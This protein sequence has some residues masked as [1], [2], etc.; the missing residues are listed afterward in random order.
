MNLA[1]FGL[2]NLLKPWSSSS[3]FLA[4]PQGPR[5]VRLRCFEPRHCQFLIPVWE[6]SGSRHCPP[7]HH[8]HY[9]HLSSLSLFEQVPTPEGKQHTGGQRGQ[10][11]VWTQ[12]LPTDPGLSESGSGLSG[13]LRGA[14]PPQQQQTPGPDTTSRAGAGIV[15]EKKGG[16][17][18]ESPSPPP[19][20][21]PLLIP[22][23]VLACRPHAAGLMFSEAPASQKADS[24]FARG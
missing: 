7:H 24:G 19:P 9:H 20:P 17:T 13:V 12:P 16:Q 14:E 1:P 5:E 15:T 10:S 4:A 23:S 11:S 22:G 8:H 3:Q 6:R 2:E 21:P 18:P